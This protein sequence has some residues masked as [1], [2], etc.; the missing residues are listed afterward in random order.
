MRSLLT[1]SFLVLLGW[2]NNAIA[3]NDPKA[4]SILDGVTKKVSALKTMKANFSLKLT[5]G[6]GG[7]VTD[8]RKGSIALKGQKYHVVLGNQEIMCDNSTVWTYNKE[9][10]E[11]QVA[12]YNPGEQSMS[13][14]KLFQPSFF[15]KE[16][17]YAYKGERKEQG[18]NCDI[19]E[20]TP[21]D[22]SKPIA[23]IE[24]M[25]DKATS[26]IAG[27]NYWEKN[28]NKYAITISNIV[29]NAELPDGMFSWN[30]KE[31]PGVEVVD[32]R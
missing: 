5:G 19:I 9:T 18:K 13:P 26:M 24:M 31:H 1:L 7:N 20:L 29:Q 17:T 6:K 2:S 8:T 25:I 27:G 4:K 16:Y 11:V 14:A 30:P 22:K 32:L 12:K 10:K 15:D 23:R 21:R 3:Q 28:G